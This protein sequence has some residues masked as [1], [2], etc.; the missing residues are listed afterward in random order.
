M[1]R[2]SILVCIAAAVLNAGTPVPTYGTYFGGAGDVNVAVAVAVD[3]SGNVIVAGYTT[4]PTLPGTA[5][6]FQPT[7]ATGFPDNRDVFIAKFNPPGTTLLWATFLGGDDLDQ[8]TAVAVDSAGSIYVVGT[9]RSSTFPV[10]P[11]AYLM[12]N[13]TPGVNGFAAKVSADG[14]SLLY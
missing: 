1:L 9:T 12:S 4:S 8:P 13:S 7:K 6:A 3:A 10:T 2:V 14:H 11:S 5:S